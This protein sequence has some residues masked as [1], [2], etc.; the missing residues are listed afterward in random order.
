[1]RAKDG[2]SRYY[3]LNKVEAS[4]LMLITFFLYFPKL[5]VHV[6]LVGVLVPMWA[7]GFLVT[8]LIILSA[9]IVLVPGSVN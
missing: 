3:L 4:P 9:L 2:M 5:P 1:M 8:L 7:A 6:T